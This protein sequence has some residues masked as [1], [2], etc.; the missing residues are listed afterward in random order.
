M[1]TPTTLLLFVAFTIPPAFAQDRPTGPTRSYGPTFPPGYFKYGPSWLGSR[2][3]PEEFAG[4]LGEK[5]PEKV[6]T[7]VTSVAVSQIGNGMAVGAWLW[8]DGPVVEKHEY[9]L[10]Y[11]LRIHTKKGEEGPLLGTTDRPKGIGYAL[12]R[13]R[14]T[15]EWNGLEAKVDITRKELSG[16]T[17]LPDVKVGTEGVFVR[18]EPQLIDLTDDKYLTPARPN[19]LMLYLLVGPNRKV[20]QVAPLSD[21]AAYT[22]RYTPEKLKQTLDDLD[23]YRVKESGVGMLLGRM[24][25]DKEVKAATKVTI[26][27]AL[28]LANADDFVGRDRDIWDVLEALAASDDAELTAAAK[29]K[30]EAIREFNLARSNPKK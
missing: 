5:R 15:S 22:A 24:L 14:A 25:D 11:Q 6:E 4:L 23:A 8:A 28:P 17:N 29:K 27:D 16:M 7:A 3:S 12:K 1:R 13:Q 20:E 2:G 30:M 10:R 9:E 19:A 26:I 21:W 18:V